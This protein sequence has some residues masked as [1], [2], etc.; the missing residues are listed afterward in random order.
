MA[1]FFAVNAMRGN[2]AKRAERSWDEYFLSANEADIIGLRDVS[3]RYRGTKAAVWALQSAGD[4]GLASGSQA[5]FTDREEA[6][7]LLS[8]A[9]DDYSAAL[10][11]A[12]TPMLK[13]RATMG[14]AQSYEALNDFHNAATQYESLIKSW[15]D[16]SLAKS[17]QERLAS[18]QDPST[19]K[20]YD[21]FCK[22]EPKSASG[23]ALDGGPAVQS[24]QP[25]GDL[26]A[27]PDLKLPEE[28]EL[29][30]SDLMPPDT[31]VPAEDSTDDATEDSGDGSADDSGDDSEKN[32]SGT[33]D[34]SSA[35]DTQPA[36][37]ETADTAAQPGDSTEPPTAT[38]QSAASESTESTEQP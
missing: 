2:Q 26:P 32:D 29:G 3:S 17:A 12:K 10:K 28:K 19:K 23:D 25:Y 24:P 36:T 8:T 21:W 37:E 14:L 22:Q 33:T 9:L 13:Q 31:S 5:M 35:T 30:T 16:S 38:E 34:G 20:F 18:L 27:N 4:V 15:P 11:A 7:S 6:K 1:L